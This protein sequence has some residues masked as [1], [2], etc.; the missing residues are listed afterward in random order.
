MS[1]GYAE[2]LDQTSVDI[3][4]IKLS[5]KGVLRHAILPNPPY[6]INRV[7]KNEYQTVFSKY[8]GSLAAPTAGL[9]FTKK[10][11]NRLSRYGV[12][13]VFITLHVGFGTFLPITGSLET[14]K[15]ECEYYIINKNS[16]KIINER[17][18]RLIVVGTTTLKALESS[19]KNGTIIPSKGLS[20]L[21]IRPGYKFKSGADALITNFHLSE[22][23]LILLTCAFGNTRRI[24]TAYNVAIEKNYRFYSLGDAMIVF[25]NSGV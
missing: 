13:I 3:F 14:H 2:I 18:G 12:K 24:M 9:H 17:N 20:E 23:T 1:G 25:D 11:L 6:I 4:I 15:T 16:A 21:F 10:I 5:S 19:S 8:N 7:G 22:S